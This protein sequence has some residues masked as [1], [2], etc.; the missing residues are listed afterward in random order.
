MKVAMRADDSA[1]K[2]AEHLVA[3]SADLMAVL[4]VL[5]MVESSVV[6]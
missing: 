1:G 4:W 6:Q 5:L 3:C 2:M